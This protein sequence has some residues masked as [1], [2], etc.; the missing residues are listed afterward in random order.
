MEIWTGNEAQYE[1]NISTSQAFWISV[2]VCPIACEITPVV[3]LLEFGFG[4][5]L[6]FLEIFSIPGFTLQLSLLLS[7]LFC[8][9]AVLSSNLLP[10]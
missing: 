2:I 7:F 3:V 10:T 9:F 4:G 5:V 8:V 1:V 6:L